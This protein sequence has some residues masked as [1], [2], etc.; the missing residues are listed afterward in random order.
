MPVGE[1]SELETGQSGDAT[2]RVLLPPLAPQDALTQVE[3]SAMPEYEVLPQATAADPLPRLLR[4]TNSEERQA[5]VRAQGPHPER[6]CRPR[7]SKDVEP[8]SSAIEALMPRYPLAMA[9][10]R[11][12]LALSRCVGAFLDEE[13]TRIGMS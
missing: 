10:I 6:R 12:D 13:P 11:L 1:G 4:A 7:R 9:R 8:A 5:S 3:Y 2:T